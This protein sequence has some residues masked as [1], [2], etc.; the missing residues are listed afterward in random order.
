[1]EWLLCLALY[2]VFSVKSWFWQAP[3]VDNPPLWVHTDPAFE[4]VR[5]LLTIDAALAAADVDL[6]SDSAASASMDKPITVNLLDIGSEEG[7]GA[8][9]EDEDDENEGEGEEPVDRASE[10]VSGS[11]KPPLPSKIGTFLCL[12]GYARLML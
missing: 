12:Y 7:V 5:E 10:A 11:R 1:M 4:C 8:G 6:D 9:E 3:G 2:H